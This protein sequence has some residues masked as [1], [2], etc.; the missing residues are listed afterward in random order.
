MFLGN[1]RAALIT[2]MVIPVS[3]LITMIG[4]VENK[5]SGN[6]MSLGALDFGIIVDGA[7]I[8]VENCIARL[9]HEQKKLGRILTKKERFE[10]VFSAS[11]EVRKAT[12]FGELIIMTVYLPILT[13][14]GVE[15]KMFVPMAL[16]VIFALGGA[17]ILSMTF[18]PAAIAIFL[19]GKVTE[20]ENPIMRASGRFYGPILELAMNYRKTVIAAACGL[21]VICTGI[22]SQMG[23]EF[24]PKLNEGDLAVHAMRIPGT[25]L[26][27]AVEMQKI[28]E[29]EIKDFPEVKTVFAKLGTA[30]VASDP[31]PP[32]VADTFIILKPKSEW[33][34]PEKSQKE[35]IETMRS[36]L[37]ELVGNKYEWTQPIE[38]RF[39]ELIS[40]VRADVAVKVFGDDMDIMLETQIKWLQFSVKSKVL[41]ML[42]WNR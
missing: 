16:T 15:G 20:K 17:M 38:M 29:N 27:E 42:R 11:K 10:V 8:I 24:I 34:D 35:L 22:A 40:G 32:N 6:L 1:I 13:L 4:M 12:M 39:N 18:V 14:T 41:L 19:S 30:E 9:A 7:V 21:L 31:M 25:S 36:Y 2:A 5:V 3:M 26:T 23:S 37:D 28:V 33:P